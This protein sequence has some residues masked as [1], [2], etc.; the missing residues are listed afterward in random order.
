MF[1]LAQVLMG[2]ERCHATQ[3]ILMPKKNIGSINFS[4]DILTALLLNIANVAV[5]CGQ[6]RIS[7]EQR[8]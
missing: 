4:R 5:S 3:G 2:Y 6:T 1:L 8:T 7:I